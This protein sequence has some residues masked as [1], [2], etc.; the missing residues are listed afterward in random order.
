MHFL[1]LGESLTLRGRDF[2]FNP[3]KDRVSSV[4]L[5]Q[6]NIFRIKHVAPRKVSASFLMQ[7][8]KMGPG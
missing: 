3:P 1:K 5:K 2:T 8:A 6:Q 4:K 7:I